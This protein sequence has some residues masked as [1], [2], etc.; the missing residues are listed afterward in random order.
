MEYLVTMTTHVPGMKR[1][2]EP[3]KIVRPRG[4]ARSVQLA[5]QGSVLGSGAQPLQPGE[6][7]TLGFRG[8]R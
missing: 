4:R 7:R 6:W 1:L 3:S 8:R 2:R 5:T